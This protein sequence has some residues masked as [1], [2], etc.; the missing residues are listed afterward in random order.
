MCGAVVVQL[1]FS[2][3]DSI[4]TA[5][6]VVLTLVVVVDVV[7][8]VGVVDVVDVV[9]VAGVVDV[10]VVVEVVDVVDDVLVVDIVVLVVDKVVVVVFVVG[11]LSFGIGLFGSTFH[12]FIHGF[13]T[14]T[15]AVLPFGTRRRVFGT[16]LSCLRVQLL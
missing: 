1:C 16:V 11:S 3:V 6:N 7:D 9:D 8:S 2:V 12:V 4:A 13:F 14:F 10:V 15:P 5:A